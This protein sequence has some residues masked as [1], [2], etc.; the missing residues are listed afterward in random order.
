MNVDEWCEHRQNDYEIE[1]IDFAWRAVRPTKNWK[2]PVSQT[3]PAD[4]AN[5]LTKDLVATAIE[6]YTG[7][8]PTFVDAED[9]SYIVTAA[10]YRATLE[11][12]SCDV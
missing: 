4:L 8:S 3:V 5:L 10:G 1:Q 2:D 9:G 7:G 6:F 12:Y 11:D